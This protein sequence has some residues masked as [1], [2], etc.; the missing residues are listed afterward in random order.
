MS[1]RVSTPSARRAVPIAPCSALSL[2][3]RYCSIEKPIGASGIEV[4][5]ERAVTEPTETFVPG[6]H[7]TPERAA[8]AV[9]RML[10]VLASPPFV[11]MFAAGMGDDGGAPEA[12]MEM[13]PPAPPPSGRALDT[14]NVSYRRARSDDIPRMAQMMAAEDL[15]PL[16][17]EEFLGGFIVADC[18]GEVV[19]TGGL[20]MYGKTGAIRSVVLDPRV[21]GTGLGRRMAE[22]MMEDA[23][24]SGA[25]QVYLFTQN[26]HAFWLHLSFEDVTLDE[27]DEEPRASWQWQF[28]RRHGAAIGVVYP[29]R[30]RLTR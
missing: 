27:W 20:E 16:F 17:I 18:D 30:K 10:A 15:P 14:T 28:I 21:R 12:M 6:S 19:G 5:Q 7:W 4:K 11:A 9:A 3:K 26:A 25:D 2:A 29:M 13:A 22:L 8:T 1:D 23:R 24:A